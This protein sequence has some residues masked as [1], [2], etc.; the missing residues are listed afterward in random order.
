MQVAD[1]TASQLED[2]PNV[3]MTLKEPTVPE[4]E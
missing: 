1:N 2:L 4:D 3:D